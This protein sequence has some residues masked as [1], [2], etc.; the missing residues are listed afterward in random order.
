M[1]TI[2]SRL[3]AIAR[4]LGLT[5]AERDAPQERY[6]CI[7]GGA[8]LDLQARPTGPADVQRGTSVPGTLT[9]AAGERQQSRKRRPVP[10][11][12]ISVPP[13]VIPTPSPSFSHSSSDTPQ[14]A[15]AAT[16]PRPSPA[17]PGAARAPA[18][19]AWWGR[20]ARGRSCCSCARRRGSISRVCAACAGSPRRPSRVSKAQ[21]QQYNSR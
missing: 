21:Q 12:L 10:P 8:I 17:C 15:S 5:E 14:V 7:L 9:Q 3:T 1:D 11:S 20:T 19:S 2:H 18:S 4:H 16:S 13:H 6:P